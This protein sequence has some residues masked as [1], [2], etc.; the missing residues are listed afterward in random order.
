MSMIP[1]FAAW[2]HHMFYWYLSAKNNVKYYRENY[3]T[4]LTFNRAVSS[5][6]VQQSISSFVS[7]EPIPRCFPKNQDVCKGG[8]LH[9]FEKLKWVLET[10]KFSYCT[11][12]WSK[13]CMWLLVILVLEI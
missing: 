11:S 6:T 12:E 9:F 4:D 2:K 5:P 1:F 7:I 10:K 8:S 3:K 13:T